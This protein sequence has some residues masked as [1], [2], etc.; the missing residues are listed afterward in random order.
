MTVNRYGFCFS[1]RLYGNE[2]FRAETSIVLKEFDFITD[3]LL[4]I[5]KMFYL[6]IA[7]SVYFIYRKFPA[8]LSFPQSITPLI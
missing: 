8:W 3:I 7:D 5:D 6:K 1:T 2:D 4:V